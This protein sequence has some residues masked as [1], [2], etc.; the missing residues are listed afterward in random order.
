MILYHARQRA[1]TEGI[2]IALFTQPARRFRCQIEGHVAV[3]KLCFQ[4]EHELLH[5]AVDGVAAEGRKGDR[6]IETV[7]E[8]GGEEFLDRLLILPFPLAA[9]ETDGIFRGIRGTGIGGHDQDH[10]AEVDLLAVVIGQFAVIHHLQQDVE[11]IRVRLFDFVQQQHAMG[12]LIDTIGQKPTLIEADIARRCADQTADRMPLHI[13]AHVEAQQFDA[14]D[15]GQLLRHF[16]LADAGGAGEQITADGLFR[17]AQART[18][19]LD[20]R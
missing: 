3:G 14:H 16:G 12:M 2:V 5:H 19:E 17:L 13:F 6:G 7:A 10:I 9:A 1:G 15:R 20:R 4:F 8:F 11:Q 18:R